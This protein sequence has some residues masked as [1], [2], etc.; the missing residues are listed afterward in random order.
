ML[1]KL[2]ITLAHVKAGNTSE[3]SLNEI[4]QIMYPLYRGK[5]SLKRCITI[6]Y[7][8]FNKGIIQ[9]WILYL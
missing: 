2:P 7:K 5:K 1:Q 8:D 3:N 4:R 6:L 9:K